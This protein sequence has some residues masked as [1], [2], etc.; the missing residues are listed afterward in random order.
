MK[1]TSLFFPKRIPSLFFIGLIT[2]LFSCQSDSEGGK[3]PLADADP[4]VLKTQYVNK[5]QQDNYFAFNLLKTTLKTEK[6]LN[7]FVSPLSVSM[8]LSM[9]LNGA[10]G[11][12]FNE[13]RNALYLSNYSLDEINDYNKTM[14]EAIL[15]IDPSTQIRIANSVWSKQGFPFE[16]LFLQNNQDYYEAEINEK[17]FN[18]PNTLKIIN[19]WCSEQTN[20]KIPKILD[21]IDPLAIMYLINAVYFKGIWVSQFEKKLTKDLPFYAEN[22]EKELVPIMR[23]TG[24]FNLATDDNAAY[25]EL[26]YGNKAFNMVIMLP[27]ESKTTQDILNN[28]NWNELTFSPRSI[29]L[30]L[31][32]F[33]T[34]C[35]YELQKQILPEMGMIQSFT[36]NADFRNISSSSGIYL[37]RVIHK[38]YIEVN[39]EGTEAAAVTA[40]EVDLTALPNS[41]PTAFIVNKPFVFV[42][43]ENSTG[44]ILFAGK[45]GDVKK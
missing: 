24:T 25:I 38:T 7:V 28:I 16:S 37:S 13:M 5:V 31:P 27:H 21:Q 32:R 3:T 12:T 45:I 41:N 39:E 40:V 8:A 34:E 1:H 19:Q 10:K 42:I 33:K 23:Q 17:D 18:D 4:I 14:R 6:Q 22:G 30:E 35:Q 29:N 43:R 26:P 9:T 2:I 15:K 36:P 44:V 20:K 11:E